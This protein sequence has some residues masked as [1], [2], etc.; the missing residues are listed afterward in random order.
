M[1][2]EIT[3]PELGESV[4]EATVS[5]WLKKEGDFVNAGDVLLELE[6]DKVN[7]EVGAKGSGILQKIQAAEGADVKVGNVLGIIEE[8]ATEPKTDQPPAAVEKAEEKKTQEAQSPSKPEPVA[9]ETKQ[10]EPPPV[11]KEEAPARNDGQQMDRQAAPQISPVAARLARDKNVDISKIAGT[12]NE[13]RVTKADVEMFIQM[14]GAAQGTVKQVPAEKEPST[15][16][17]PSANLASSESVA[18]SGRREERTRMSRRRRTIAQ[19]LLEASQTT[20]MLTT[21]NEIDM[22][23]IM[24][25]RKRHNEEFQKRYGIK[26]GFMSFFVKASISALRAF[27]QVNAQIDGDEIVF[28]HYYDIGMAVGSS[29]GLVVPVIR[30]ADRLSFAEIEQQIKDLVAKTEQGKLSVED[31]RGGTF[32]ITNGGVFGS[33]LSTPILNPPQVGIL[34]LH[35]IEERPIALNGQVII[36]PM[37]YVALSYDHR[38]VD[39]REAVQFLVHIKQVLEDPAWMLVSG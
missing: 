31:L 35:K 2:I 7:L 19:R 13:G 27:P 38:M 23:A 4:L 25:I 15:E 6:T 1:A 29:E 26:L 8:K 36:R 16:A 10:A 37:M 21:F 17:Q 33:L 22:S 5:R 39:G 18:S 30:D 34:G 32:T 24:D 3:V 28:K 14:Q 12:G 9:A 20:A 11:E